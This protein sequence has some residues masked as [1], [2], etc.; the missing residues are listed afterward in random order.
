[1][2][3]KMPFIRF[4]LFATI[5]IWLI[6]NGIA[7]DIDDSNYDDDEDYKVSE[8][9]KGVENNIIKIWTKLNL[10]R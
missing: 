8:L 3:R 10:M 9:K 2:K 6:G 4:L 7:N 1:M 5:I